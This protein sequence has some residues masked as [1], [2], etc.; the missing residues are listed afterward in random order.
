[1]NVEG[2]CLVCEGMGLSESQFVEAIQTFSGAAKRLELVRKEGTFSCYKDFAHSPSKL[3]A[4]TAAVK[5]QFPN[6]KIVACMEL[7]TFSSLTADFLKEYNGAMDTA[8][9]AFVY[10]NPH[11]IQHKKLSAISVSQVKDA[12]VRNDLK[13]STDS[14][15]LIVELTSRNWNNSVLLLMTS[16]NFDGVDFTQFANSLKL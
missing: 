15:S 1:M 16:G 10:Y 14:N 2:A 11:T 4:T 6:R 5:K 13:V 3:K 9:E 12:F 8:D 7:H